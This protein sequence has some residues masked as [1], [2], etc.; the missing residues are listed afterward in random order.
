M[1]LNDDII[2]GGTTTTTITTSTGN[3]S[4]HNN[5]NNNNSNG[6]GSPEYHYHNQQEYYGISGGSS[7]SSSVVGMQRSLYAC[8]DWN[9]YTSASTTTTTTLVNKDAVLGKWRSKK[10]RPPLQDSTNH[11][12]PQLFFTSPTRPSSNT[13]S[14]TNNTNNNNNNNNNNNTNNNS[15]NDRSITSTPSHLMLPSLSTTITSSTL[16]PCTSPPRRSTTKMMASPSYLPSPRRPSP[17]TKKSSPLMP[18]PIPLVSSINSPLHVFENCLYVSA[19]GN[20]NGRIEISSTHLK[21][22][23]HG[24]RLFKRNS[25]E[26][27]PSTEFTEES[28]EEMM[29]KTIIRATKEVSRRHL[30]HLED[31]IVVPL[32]KIS[33][34]YPRTY[35]MRDAALELF[36]DS[37]QKS[38]FLVSPHNRQAALSCLIQQAPHVQMQDVPYHHWFLRKQYNKKLPTITTDWTKG[39]LSNYDYLLALNRMAGRT[40]HDISNYPIMPWVL[41][42]YTST[43]VPDLSDRNNFRDLT[44]PMGALDPDRLAKFLQKYNALKS[45]YQK[46]EENIPPFMYGSHYSNTGGVVLH[47]LVRLPP[48]ADLHRQLQVN[49]YV[50]QFTLLFLCWNR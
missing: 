2:G 22:V 16:F 27:L 48:F 42:N 13:S 26:D 32:N 4:L 7:S 11:N 49:K 23:Y 33:H 39:L 24:P 38:I 44:K 36:F 25:N 15:N 21:F 6:N 3:I 30:Q 29:N 18:P 34:V 50:L 17:I 5:N 14:S 31:E 1:T 40:Y 35:M 47:Y 8:N 43:T 9:H 46:K 20:R 37:L 28:Y 12:S 19:H 10:R 41:S 45:S